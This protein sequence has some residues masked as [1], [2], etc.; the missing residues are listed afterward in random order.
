MSV[1]DTPTAHA[2]AAAQFLVQLRNIVQSINGFTFVTPGRRRVINATASVPDPFLQT[3]A[4]ALDASPML[5]SAAQVDG[6]QLRD[7]VVFTNAF[8]AV[9]IELDLAARGLRETIASRRYEAGV[10]A[11]RAYS[12]AKSLNRPGDRALLIPYIRDMRRT[13]G[14]GRTRQTVPGDATQ[15]APEAP[16]P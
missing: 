7:A 3:V 16:A 4:V 11:L 1:V 15:P 12:M 9:A 5:A 13:L 6:R 10:S 8:E 14:R 2:E